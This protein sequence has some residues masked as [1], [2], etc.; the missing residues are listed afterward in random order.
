VKFG[1]LQQASGTELTVQQSQALRLRFEEPDKLGVD[2]PGGVEAFRQ[3]AIR[4]V[5]FSGER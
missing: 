5:S 2:G 1:L 4:A 3:L